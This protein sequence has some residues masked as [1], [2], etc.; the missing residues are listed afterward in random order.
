MR[1]DRAYFTL[2][3]NTVV[4]GWQRNDMRR[5]DG[6][7]RVRRMWALLA[8]AAALCVTVP[9]SGLCVAFGPTEGTE[10][11]QKEWAVYIYCG[12]D[13]DFE[14]AAEFAL[15]QCVAALA[16]DGT[17]PGLL[18]VIAFLDRQGD[19]ATDVY[20]VTPTGLSV[21]DSWDSHERDSSDPET[22]TE[23]LDFVTPRYP[24][25]NTLVVVKNGHAW[26]GVC[27][28]WNSQD[29]KYLMP[30]DGLASVLNGR[31]IDVLA[32]DGDNMASLE[33]AYELRGST[34]Y[35]VGTQQ[36]MPLDGLP[37]YLFLKDMATVS[38][39]PKAVRRREDLRRG[40][41]LRR[42]GDVHDG[43]G[44]ARWDVCSTAGRLG[45]VDMGSDIQELHSF[46]QGQRVDRQDG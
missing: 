30:V 23:F 14:E 41:G 29:E 11:A 43:G 44:V 10:V 3:V 34:K 1:G 36:D 27:P 31:S 9:T 42:R 25:D 40:G 6:N 33:V 46:C 7:M 35:F 18:H 24:G 8:I 13:N 15:D 26:C 39:A 38:M 5:G 45:R 19:G 12:A 21:V 16:A 17:D 37:Y 28:D 32:L 2:I 20:E 22:M 4:S